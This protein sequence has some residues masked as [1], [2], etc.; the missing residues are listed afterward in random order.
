MQH[1]SYIKSEVLLLQFQ[2][3]CYEINNICP[4]KN[5]SYTILAVKNE[6]TNFD[7]DSL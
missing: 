7:N 5:N 4:Y 1:W 3:L 2:T 6:R